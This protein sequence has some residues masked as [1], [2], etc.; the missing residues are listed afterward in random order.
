MDEDTQAMLRLLSL[1]NKKH[2]RWRIGHLEANKRWISILE[3]S[4][5]F[6]SPT[7][8]L[9]TSDAKK[10]HL[11]GMR[12]CFDFPAL[13]PELQLAVIEWLDYADLKCL[14]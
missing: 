10:A 6:A 1:A 11:A 13:L 2:P 14:E 4:G 12:Q 8:Q 3:S 7:P 5:Y 9:S